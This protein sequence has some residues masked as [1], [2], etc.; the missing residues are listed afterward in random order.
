MAEFFIWL[1]TLLVIEPL[2]LDLNQRFA[3]IGAPAELVR[4][5]EACTDVAPAALVMRAEDD[6]WWATRSTVRL[7]I[8]TTT[9]G[10]LLGDTVPNCRDAVLQ[11][12]ALLRATG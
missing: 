7:I 9:P 11:A 6:W 2:Q 4:Q 12:E 10:E 3:S 1:I 5:V 8:G